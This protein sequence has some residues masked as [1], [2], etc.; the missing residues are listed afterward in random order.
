MRGRLTKARARTTSCRAARGKRP[1]GASRSNVVFAIELNRSAASPARRAR[2]TRRSDQSVAAEKDV[3]QRASIGSNQNFLKDR[4]QPEPLK[5]RRREAIDRLAVDAYRA[6]AR[7]RH[8]RQK[9]DQ[10]AL[11]GAI[12]AKDRVNG[13]G[14]E[15]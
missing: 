6:P 7:R 11:A 2:G 14:S 5:H 12:L 13:S 3:V 1:A 15:R 9:L 8:T 4:R 10:R